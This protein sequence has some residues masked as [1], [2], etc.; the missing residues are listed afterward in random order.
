MASQRAVDLPISGGGHVSFHLEDTAFVR[1][2]LETVTL[3]EQKK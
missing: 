2:E 1:K 3:Q